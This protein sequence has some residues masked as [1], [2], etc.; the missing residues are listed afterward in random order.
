MN[1]HVYIEN[2]PLSNKNSLILSIQSEIM[3]RIVIVLLLMFAVIS[4]AGA[5]DIILKKNGVK[6]RCKITQ[7]DSAVI[8]YQVSG[9][10]T[11]DYT[12]NRDEVATYVYGKKT[13]SQGAGVDRFSLGLG[14][15]LDFG[16]IGTNILLYPQKNIGLFGGVGYALAGVGLNGGIKIR[17]MPHKRLDPY[18]LGMY[19]YNSSIYVMNATQFNKLFNGTTVGLGMDIHPSKNKG[20]WAFAIH[21]PF[22]GS[23]VKTYVDNLKNYYGV[24]FRNVLLPIWISAGY[25]FNIR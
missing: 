15:G 8:H 13:V 1:I 3:K 2:H 7:V 25:R 6:I 24:E 22:R 5:Q 19:G 4:M 9:M 17:F 23:D 11:N 20:Y 16:G 14:F 21:I 12:I 10:A 18:I